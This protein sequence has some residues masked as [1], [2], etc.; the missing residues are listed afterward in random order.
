MDR[1]KIKPAEGLKIRDSVSK[2]FLPVE[3]KEVVWNSYWE[4]R[5]NCGDVVLV[6]E[7]KP[8]ANVADVQ[9]SKKMGDKK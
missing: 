5:L 1:R 7:E 4:R 6:S 9:L 3:G 8:S 2:L